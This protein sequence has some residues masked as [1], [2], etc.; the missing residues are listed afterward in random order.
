MSDAIPAEDVDAEMGF[1]FE[2]SPAAPPSAASGQTDGPDALV[3]S[4]CSPGTVDLKAPIDVIPE[5]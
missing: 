5:S 1:S 4:P 3:C 2:A